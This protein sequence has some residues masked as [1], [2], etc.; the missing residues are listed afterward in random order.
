MGDGTSLLARLPK[1]LPGRN[2]RDDSK[3]RGCMMN[4]ERKQ[5][6]WGFWLQWLL[7]SVVGLVVGGFLSL[8]IG[9]GVGE[10]VEKALGRVAGYIVA[11][12]LFGVLWGGGLGIMQWFVLRTQIAR[13]G[14]WAL[15][16]AIAGAVGLARA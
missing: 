4:A 14:W 7:A 3:N 8:P 2:P 10:G 5:I 1:N 9:Y 15:A 13:A 6:G 16:S 11:G 12:A